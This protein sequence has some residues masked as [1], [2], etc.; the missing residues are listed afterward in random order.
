MKIVQKSKILLCECKYC[1]TVFRPKWRNLRK[2]SR[3]VKEAVS[4]PA[5]K[6]TNYVNFARG[7][8]SEIADVELTKEVLKK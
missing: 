6:G 7:G 1:H 8:T 2:S 5:C 3:F 4:C